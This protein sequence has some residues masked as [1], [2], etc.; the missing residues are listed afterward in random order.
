M[1]TRPEE[2]R[3]EIAATRAELAADVDR[4][5]D[6]TSPAR[7]AR[8]RTDRMRQAARS[9]RERVMGTPSYAA[10]R[11]RAGAHHA[12]DT[13]SHGAHQAAQTVKE[14]SQQAAESVRHGAQQAAEVV[15]SAPEQAMRGTQGNPLAAGLIAF[16]AGLLAAALIPRTQAEEQAVGQLREQ[17]GDVLEPVKEAGRETA[18]QLGQDAKEVAGQAA[19]QVRQTAS[20]AA[21]ATADHARE[22]ARQVS[23]QSR[24]R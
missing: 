7:I 11:T 22:Q 24:G 10:D 13:V 18:Q 21:G 8:R 16:G 2:V 12:A 19:Q 5:A 20:E 1:G 6:R 15:R 14:G 4:L 17:V 3:S 9:F 23:E